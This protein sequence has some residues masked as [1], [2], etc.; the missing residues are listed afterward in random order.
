MGF[1]VGLRFLL[2]PADGITVPPS[3]VK[4]TVKFQFSNATLCYAMRYD[5]FNRGFDLPELSPVSSGVST[6]VSSGVSGSV[7]G[8][9]S[10]LVRLAVLIDVGCILAVTGAV[11]GCNVCLEGAEDGCGVS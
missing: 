10:S 9:V 4:V 8:W 11:D 7:A 3:A 2:I 1:L 5:I 6:G